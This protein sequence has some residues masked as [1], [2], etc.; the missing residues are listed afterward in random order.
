MKKRFVSKPKKRGVLLK[1]FLWLFVAALSLT[2]TFNV[3]LKVSFK[4]LLGNISLHENLLEMGLNRKNFLS[5]DLLNP[6][7]L[8]KLGLNYKIDYTPVIDIEELELLQRHQNDKNP[9]VYIYSTHD[10]EEYDSTLM[11]AYNIKYNVKIGGYI[12]SDCLKDLGVPSYVE[13]E[14]MTDYLR[15][16]GLNYNHSYY[17]S[18]HYIG[19]RLSEYPSI[20][21]IIDVHRDGIPRSASVM[22]IDGKS[23][24]KVMFVVALS[25]EGAE[26]N[27]AL[28]E[29]MSSLLPVGLTRKVSRGDG[30][31]ANGVFNQNLKDKSLIIEVGGTENTIEEVANTMELLS[32]AIFEVLNGGERD[33]Q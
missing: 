19:M 28:A 22:T 6:S 5:F 29:K 30:V 32:K 18:A 12:L 31:G 24:A 15:A 26:A 20:D 2:V 3:L 14:S 10:T 23:Y 7:D 21:M 17:A 4:G 13:E 33:G 11:E 1:V 25:Y 27:I 16:N 9:R 8:L